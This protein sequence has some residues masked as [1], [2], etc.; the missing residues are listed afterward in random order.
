[1][2]EYHYYNT[3]S[4]KDG[5]RLLNTNLPR[6]KRL[7]A[8]DHYQIVEIGSRYKRIPISEMLDYCQKILE[9][10]KQFQQ[11]MEESVSELT[12]KLIEAKSNELGDSNLREEFKELFHE[13]GYT[14]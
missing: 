12:S 10:S 1:M 6:L 11:H 3:I 7:S 4:L 8:K 13:L 14:I 2:Q 9:E 5:C